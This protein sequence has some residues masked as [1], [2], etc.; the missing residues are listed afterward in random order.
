MEPQV[1]SAEG[2]SSLWPS[3]CSMQLSSPSPFFATARRLHPVRTRTVC[4]SPIER[5]W[6]PPQVFRTMQPRSSAASSSRLCPQL[7]TAWP[8]LQQ[9]VN[10]G[11]GT[12]RGSPSQARECETSSCRQMNRMG[13][14]CRSAPPCACVFRQSPGQDVKGLCQYGRANLQDFEIFL[15]HGRRRSRTR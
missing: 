15:K 3:L 5:P 9:C 12:H 14:S 13:Q 4:P 7:A 6:L 8:S 2:P 10:S 11:C 1:V